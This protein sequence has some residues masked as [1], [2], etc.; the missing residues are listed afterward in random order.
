[1]SFGFSI[2]DFFQ[3]I[4]LARKAYRNCKAAPAEFLEAG[5]AAR[6]L[7]VIFEVIE[8]DV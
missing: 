8:H 4:E 2:G 1:M 7:Y 3:L 6:G 5:R